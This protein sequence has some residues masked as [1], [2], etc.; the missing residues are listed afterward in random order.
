MRSFP[1]RI[2]MLLDGD[3]GRSR[4]GLKS[5]TQLEAIRASGREDEVVEVVSLLG[6]DF[7]TQPVPVSLQ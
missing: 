7:F 3:P 4:D 1:L 2:V 6:L 5:W